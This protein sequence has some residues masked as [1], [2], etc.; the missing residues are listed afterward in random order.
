MKGKY[1]PI[2]LSILG[3]VIV[4][5]LAFLTWVKTAAQPLDSRAIMIGG[6]FGE[7]ASSTP[8]IVKPA[9][10]AKITSRGIY[11]TAYSAG[12]V[13]KVDK[14]LAEIEGSSINSVVIDIKDYSGNLCYDSQIPMVN[15]LGLEEIKIRDLKGVV[16]KLHQHGLYAIARIAVFQDPALAT[17]KP[18]W[19]VGNKETGKTWQDRKGLSWVDPANPAVWDYHILIAQEA[20]ALGFDEINLDYVRFPSDGAI[21]AMTFPV[22]KGEGTKADVMRNFFSYFSDKLKDEPAYLSVD[23]F[24]LTTTVKNDM[25]IGQLLENTSPYFDYICP[26]VYPSHYPNGYLG[27][28]NPAEHPYDI[29]YGAIKTA[30]ERL[31]STTP[32]RAKIRPW[33]QDFDLGAVYTAGMIKQEIK[34]SLDAGGDGFLVWDPKNLYTWEGLK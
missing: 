12:S 31:A 15:E 19:A 2:L 34:A 18:E 33:I 25:N 29:I 23:L 11:L 6:F 20:I 26:M 10:P 22:W 21:S 7:R 32:Q 3:L 14:V 24:G 17:K 1:V 8:I 5:G 13:T 27:F 16:D 9:K 28:N 4:L 30:N